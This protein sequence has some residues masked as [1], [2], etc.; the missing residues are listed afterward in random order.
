[1]YPLLVCA[2][3]ALTVVFER[4][5]FWIRVAWSREPEKVNN[6]L[7]FIE[8][9]RFK[10]AQALVQGS[11]DYVT[12]VLVCGITHR[13]F[14]LENALQMAAAEEIKKMTRFHTILDTIITLAPLLGILG[15]VIGIIN[16]F[17]MLGEAGISDP[18][19]VTAG[20]AQALLTTAAG[21]TVAILT[22]LPYN[23][24]NSRVSE[25]ALQIEKYGS[26]LEIVYQRELKAEDK[27][28]VKDD[29]ASKK[30]ST[31]F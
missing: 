11:K 23:Y 5:I 2:F 1:M 27:S 19:A 17:D 8:K 14:D 20:I 31:I 30:E 18:K 22:L 10:E 29:I 6:L 25:A 21:L 15:T 13:E 3:I 7:E 28:I 26:S 24:F 16:S 4:F 12:R 9:G